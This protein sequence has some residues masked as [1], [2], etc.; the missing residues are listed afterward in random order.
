LRRESHPAHQCCAMRFSTADKVNTGFAIALGIVLVIGISSI[1]SIQRFLA[2]S[3]EMGRTNATILELH[4]MLVRLVDAE[5]AQRGF[6]LTGDEADLEPFHRASA[7]VPR[8]LARLADASRA[9]TAQWR[10]LS[11]LAELAALR[12]DLMA[13]VI[14]ARREG[15][16][17][18]AT[19]IIA[20]GG[21]KEAMDSI[22]VIASAVQRAELQRLTARNTSA[23][24]RARL[25][26]VIIASGSIFAFLVVLGATMLIRRDY[27]ERRRAEQALRDS[28]TLLSQFMENLP[29]GV[30]VVDAQW[31]P[32]FTNNAAV[33][34]LGMSVLV[35]IEHSPLSLLRASDGNPCP[36]AEWPLNR[37]LAGQTTT[38][39]D[40]AV[41][42]DGRTVPLQVSA[43]PI[44]DAGGR[45][46]Y[47][48]AT[49]SDITD[50]RQTESALWRR[51][52]QRTRTARRASSS[53]A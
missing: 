25:A 33:Q 1:A 13:T 21:G 19:A 42:V 9:D 52:R 47:A 22:R 27:T 50:H 37:A 3:G 36:T 10:R 31:Q 23:E 14:R 39:D 24:A 41:H 48:I 4:G 17:D 29:I 45:I 46:A 44:Y 53:P 6:V 34:I 5:S 32:R 8:E 11:A 18:A 35:D 38:I 51:R 20:P 2:V 15:G 12:L 7:T 16:L 28:E 26:L 43:A 30:L 40:A 49:F